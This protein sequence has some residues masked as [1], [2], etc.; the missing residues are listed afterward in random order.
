MKD[1]FEATENK[2]ETQVCS[3]KRWE[4]IQRQEMENKTRHMRIKSTK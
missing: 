1:K 3:E 4:N 2:T